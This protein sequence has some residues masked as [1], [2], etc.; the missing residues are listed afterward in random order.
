MEL[1]SGQVLDGFDRRVLEM[2]A[3][4]GFIR[5]SA[6][7]FRLKS[8][9]ESHVYVF[10]REDLTDHQDLVWGIGRKIADLVL[11]DADRRKD[12]RQQCLIG[13]PTAGTA[14]AQAAAMVNWS[15]ERYRFPELVNS[16]RIAFRIMREALKTHGAH[17]D[18][19]NGKPQPAQ[20]YWTVDNVVTDGGTK[21]EAREKLRESGYPVADMP[22]LVLVDRQQGGIKRMEQAGFANIVVVYRLL[23]L[24]FAFR[25][26]GLWPEEAVR[27]VEEEI[28]AHQLVA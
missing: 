1:P 16:V 11:Q 17:P 8:G 9:V 22:A 25:E 10:G 3:Q 13:L 5:W 24:T 21:L 7:P 15:N 20:T 23:D 12:P 4:Y 2:F 28:R 6:Q 27:A 18:W 26:L 14:L 19:V